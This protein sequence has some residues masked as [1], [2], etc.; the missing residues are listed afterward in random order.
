MSSFPNIVYW[1]DCLCSIVYFFPYHRLIAHMFV[2]LFMGF[3]PIPL[4][5]FVPVPNCFD[6]CSFVVESE[7]KERDSSSSGLL[8]QDCFGYSEIFYVSIRIV[9]LFLLAWTVVL[10][11]F[12]T[13]WKLYKVSLFYL[14]QLHGTYSD[15]KIQSLI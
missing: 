2:G 13:G 7:V 3:Y 10:Q 5:V 8:S 6:H 9:K 14:L 1:R 11:G 15:L 12:T 4:S